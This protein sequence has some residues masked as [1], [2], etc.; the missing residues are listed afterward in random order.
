MMYYAIIVAVL[1][2]FTAY[3]IF[4]KQKKVM[5]RHPMW[6][7]FYL[8]LSAAASAFM[9]SYYFY[10]HN[11]TRWSLLMGIMFALNALMQ[12]AELR[13]YGPKIQS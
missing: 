3:E 4:V 8:G 7:G 1:M 10:G 12:F 2:L 13:F 9:F 11:S 6:L 5:R